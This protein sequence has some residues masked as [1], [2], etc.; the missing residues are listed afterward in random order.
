MPHL[1]E[2]TTERERGTASTSESIAASYEHPLWR[3]RHPVGTEGVATTFT[4]PAEQVLTR[5][6]AYRL[7]IPGYDTYIYFVTEDGTVYQQGNWGVA[8]MHVA[9]E[10]SVHAFLRRVIEQDLCRTAYNKKIARARN[11]FIQ[12]IEGE[13]REV[14]TRLRRHL[15]PC[16]PVQVPLQVDQAL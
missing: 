1:L 12:R 10:S 13:D 15:A 4:H 14:L 16:P 3:E 2:R 6:T 7:D 8:P 9:P 5:A 11:Q